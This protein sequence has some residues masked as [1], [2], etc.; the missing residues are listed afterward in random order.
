MRRP[1][2][3]IKMCADPHPK[4]IGCPPKEGDE[5][6]PQPQAEWCKLYDEPTPPGQYAHARAVGCETKHNMR[7]ENWCGTSNPVEPIVDDRGN[8]YTLWEARPRNYDFAISRQS[9]TKQGCKASLHRA[10]PL[11]GGSIDL[12][13]K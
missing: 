8:Y 13:S 5:L 10:S 9:R 7:A 11:R 2:P 3:E 12:I 4:I 6:M 1:P